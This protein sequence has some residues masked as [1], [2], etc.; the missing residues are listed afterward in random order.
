MQPH[1]QRRNPYRIASRRRVSRWAAVKANAYPGWR[2][3]HRASSATAHAAFE[4]GRFRVLLRQRRLLADGVPVELG[5]RAFD[6]LLALVEANGSLLLKEEAMARVWPGIV[7]SEENLK[8][9][10][11]ALRRALGADRDV[12]R[13]EFGRG[14]R[15]IGAVFSNA[16]AG[17]RRC[18][19]RA[20]PR[21]GRTLFPQHCWRSLRCGFTLS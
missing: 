3:T 14:Y 12:I 20:K 19:E 10:V 11:S 13:T 6:L 21:S 9:Q 4:F 2:G 5:T 1:D 7:V 17:A 15:L 8:V 18:P 16:A